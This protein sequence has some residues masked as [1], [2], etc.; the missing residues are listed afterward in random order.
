[1]YASI[2][3]KLVSPPALQ[4]FGVSGQTHQ[5]N[6]V[7][8][9]TENDAKAIHAP[10]FSE[11]AITG[12]PH[13]LRVMSYNAWLLHEPNADIYKSKSP[14]ALNA[15]ASVILKGHANLVLLQE[16]QS[17]KALQH[18]VD[19]VLNPMAVSQHQAP[20][21][22]LGYDPKLEKKAPGEVPIGQMFLYKKP[23]KL[24]KQEVY[25]SKDLPKITSEKEPLLLRE[26]HVA[27]FTLPIGKH[28]SQPLI[29]INTHI[30]APTFPG[31]SRMTSHAFEAYATGTVRLREAYGLQHVLN[32]VRKDYHT[33][34]G[35]K[36]WFLI[37]GDFN[38]D[39]H[40]SVTQPVLEVITGKAKRTTFPIYDV[41]HDTVVSANQYMPTKASRFYIKKPL[42]RLEEMSHR[43]PSLFTAYYYP[44]SGLKPV[45]FDYLFGS[46]SLQKASSSH[47]LRSPELNTTTPKHQAEEKLFRLASDH[48]PIVVEIDLEKAMHFKRLAHKRLNVQG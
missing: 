19:T 38:T 47:Y 10:H 1:M 3:T 11:K 21:E 37:G 31:L 15:L 16:V 6:V 45:H 35:Q 24:V 23:L 13:S 26:V 4:R 48:D 39:P 30:M 28:K 43:E 18:F 46:P 8:P 44:T 22:W 12:T 33:S 5:A 42:V 27:H 9:S 40:W 7:T 14:E 32:Q 29:A 34:T 2:S 36:P 17:R 20:Y 41:E 25:T